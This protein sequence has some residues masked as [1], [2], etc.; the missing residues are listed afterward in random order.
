LT[1]QLFLSH[2]QAKILRVL[3]ES[4]IEKVG[5]SITVPIDV[6][7]IAATNAKLEKMNEANLFRHDLYYRL[8]VIPLL[9]PPL[10]ERKDDL[11][12]LMEHFLAK[13]NMRLNK[14]IKGFS[15]QVTD[16]F[17]KHN[18]PGN[19]RELEN[20]IEY[21]VN[22]EPGTF[23]S[24]GYLPPSFKISDDPLTP[25]SKENSTTSKNINDHHFLYAT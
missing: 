15:T 11:S 14:N 18:W 6:R 1:E 17:M 16:L 20:I 7:I 23:I 25:G 22:M 4:S 9:I 24:L 21:A 8:N 2:L 13:Y 10:R 19:I 12:M 3:E 5:G